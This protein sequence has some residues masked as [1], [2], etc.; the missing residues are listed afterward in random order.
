M[1]AISSIAV[2]RIQAGGRQ[3]RQFGASQFCAGIKNTS[4]QRRQTL[5]TDHS[6]QVVTAEAAICP[7]SLASAVVTDGASGH[8]GCSEEGLVNAQARM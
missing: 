6:R 2:I 8:T 7:R 4:K 3:E 5:F 1:A